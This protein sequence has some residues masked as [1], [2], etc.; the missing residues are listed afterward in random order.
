MG[1]KKYLNEA[2]ELNCLADTLSMDSHY[3]PDTL[4]RFHAL[5]QAR[6]EDDGS[7]LLQEHW[8]LYYAVIGNNIFSI[9]HYERAIELVHR[10][11]TIGGPVGDINEEYVDGL[12][13]KI[14]LLSRG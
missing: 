13:T 2:D 6:G 9:K 12:K 14:D 10:L 7:I 11:L 1:R 4:S 3:T 8:A 5:L